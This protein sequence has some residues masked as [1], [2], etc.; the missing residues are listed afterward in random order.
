VTAINTL[1]QLKSLLCTS[2]NSAQAKPQ[3]L[4]FPTDLAML[5]VLYSLCTTSTHRREGFLS[6]PTPNIKGQIV[7]STGL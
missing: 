3:T 5:A 4:A 1:A 6:F 7:S 2:M